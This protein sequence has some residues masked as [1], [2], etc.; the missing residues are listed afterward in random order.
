M[1]AMFSSA[2]ALGAPSEADHSTLS[3]SASVPVT[4]LRLDLKVD[5]EARRIFGDAAYTVARGGGRESEQ[6]LVLD[7]HSLEIKS[8]SLD[9][10]LADWSLDAPHAALGTALRV[11]LTPPAG[12]GR[13]GR[14]GSGGEGGEEGGE[15]GGGP[16]VVTIRYSTTASAGAIQWLPPAQTSGKQHPF[17]FTQCQAI[18]ARAMV[19]C[20]DSPGVKSP[21]TASLTVPDGLVGLMSAVCTAFPAASEA[22]EGGRRTFQFEQKVPMASYLLAIAAGNLEKRDVVRLPLPPIAAP[23]PVSLLR[24]VPVVGGR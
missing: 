10:R 11:K 13:G 5:F 24:V 19:P 1:A 16:H 14:G 20:Q 3:S 18:H 17:M 4:S 2:S 22:G 15:G 21:Y 12:G 9:G 6:E 8:V 23:S 7:T